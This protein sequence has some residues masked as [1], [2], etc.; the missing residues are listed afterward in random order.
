MS[1]IERVG[2]HE[3]CHKTTREIENLDCL[4]IV[5]VHVQQPRCGVGIDVNRT[6]HMFHVID[7]NIRLGYEAARE[8][9]V[10]DVAVAVV[11][12]IA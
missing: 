5:S 11:A 4:Y 3:G 8:G 12:G 1:D 10:I 2:A 6:V 9:D 7:I